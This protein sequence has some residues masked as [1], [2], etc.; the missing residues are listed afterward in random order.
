[1]ENTT[2]RGEDISNPMKIIKALDIFAYPVEWYIGG[3]KKHGTAVGGLRSAGIILMSLSMLIYSA[4]LLFSN[5]KGSFIYYDIIYTNGTTMNITYYDDFEIFLTVLGS[6]KTANLDFNVV[7]M[8]LV[9][10]QGI[11]ANNN[12][13]NFNMSLA[14]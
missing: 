10:Q 11:S 13:N 9:Q 6:S 4:Y 14:K 5:K 1:M 8:S 3:S 7:N 2:T 12:G